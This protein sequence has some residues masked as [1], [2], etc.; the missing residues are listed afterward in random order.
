MINTMTHP[1]VAAPQPLSFRIERYWML[2]LPLVAV[3]AAVYLFPLVKVLWISFS[4]PQIGLQNYSEIFT[5]RTI[6]KVLVT[7]LKICIITTIL[8][9][10]IGYL[11]SYT[12]VHIG[13]RHQ[14]LMLFC[15]LLPF[16]VSVLVRAFSWLYALGENGPANSAL[17]ALGIIDTPIAM[18]RSQIGVIIGMTH[19]MIPYA[20][21]PL[22]SNLKGI[23]PM[24]VKAARGLGAGSVTA[25]LRVYLPMSLPGIVGAGILVF[26]FSLGFFVTPVILGGGKTVMISEYIS[27]E[28][29]TL[30]NWGMGTMLAAVLLLTVFLIL[31]LVSRFV[32]VRQLFG[33][34]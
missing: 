22:F 2:I 23:D 24:Y 26:I 1:A 25:F 10:L 4:D 27:M 33:A 32:D 28:I 20:V 16:W 13:E 18:V 8:S 9:V 21:L 30:V 14:L 7:T 6:Q 29:L 15:V 34:K 5:N 3:L 17:M 11:I 19:Y 31:V 12:L